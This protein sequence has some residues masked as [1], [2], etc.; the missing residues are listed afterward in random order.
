MLFFSNLP[1]LEL[2]YHLNVLLFPIVFLS[3][4]LTQKCR[5]QP[6]PEHQLFCLQMQIYSVQ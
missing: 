5:V 2:S 1:G 3:E 6:H 4:T